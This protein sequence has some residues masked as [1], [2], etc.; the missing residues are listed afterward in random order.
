ML[1]FQKKTFRSTKGFTLVELLVVI[2]IIGILIALLLPAVQ[3]AREAARRM[4]CSNKIKQ[5]ALAMHTYHDAYKSLPSRCFGIPGPGNA[6]DAV[7]NRQRYSAWIAILPFMEQQ[8]LSDRIAAHPNIQPMDANNEL[9]TGGPPSSWQDNPWK[10]RFGALTCPSDSYGPT[11][12]DDTIKGSNYCVSQGDWAGHAKNVTVDGVANSIQADP[13]ARGVFGAMVWRNLGSITDGTSNTT[14][15]SERVILNN[16]F[17]ILGGA[18]IN[19]ASAVSNEGGVGPATVNPA[20]CMITRGAKGQYNV[21]VANTGNQ[22]LGRRW[23]E[24]GPC[25]NLFSTIMP[26]N[27]PSCYSSG[28]FSN[29]RLLNP[30]T[31]FHTGGVNLALA[32]ASVTFVSDT[33]HYGSVTEPTLLRTSGESLFGIWGAAGSRNGGESTS[34]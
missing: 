13:Q 4:T 31:S 20:D 1:Q 10:A 27:A 33:I 2:A 8:A 21:D 11:M 12:G 5:L 30:P 23:T 9:W 6:L 14:F 34:L 22:D 7:G 25:S 29:D 16:R 3:A 24:G 15:I 18:V 19:R 26:P 32:D 28:G 17:D